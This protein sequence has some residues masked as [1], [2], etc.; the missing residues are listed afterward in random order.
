MSSP[1]LDFVVPN[2]SSAS[3]LHFHRSPIS[4]YS[5]VWMGASSFVLWRVVPSYVTSREK[6]GTA[7]SRVVALQSFCHVLCLRTVKSG[8]N[9]I[10]MEVELIEF[11][12]LNFFHLAKLIR[13]RLIVHVGTRDE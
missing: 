1:G 8:M 7:L 5:A 9:G 6:F 10:L 3:A 12:K 11:K 4:T 2:A 13:K